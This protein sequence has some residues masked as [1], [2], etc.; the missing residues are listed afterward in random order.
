MVV[1]VLGECIVVLTGVQGGGQVV[2]RR[3]L[4]RK[5]CTSSKEEFVVRPWYQSGCPLIPMCIAHHTAC[6]QSSPMLTVRHAG[7]FTAFFQLVLGRELVLGKRVVGPAREQGKGHAA[8]A[9]CLERKACISSTEESLLRPWYQSGCSLIPKS[10]AHWTSRWQGSPATTARHGWPSAVLL[11]L[12]LGCE[13]VRVAVP[14]ELAV[15]LALVLGGRAL[16]AATGQG[17]GHVVLRRCLARKAC[18]S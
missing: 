5:T 9:R 14:V 6:W 12:V 3:C 17:N 7:P 2:F 15:G 4:E 10:I 8:L 13:P 11:Q 16:A 18:T 1:V